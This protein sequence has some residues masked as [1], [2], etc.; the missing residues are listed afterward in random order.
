MVYVIFYE[1]V[2]FNCYEGMILSS[3]PHVVFSIILISVFR[4]VAAYLR[5]MFCTHTTEVS[6]SYVYLKCVEALPPDQLRSQS[7][8]IS[9]ICDFKAV[10]IAGSD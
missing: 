10:C 5:T 4:L 6:S 2:S 1:N 7:E 3:Y 9:Y 8:D